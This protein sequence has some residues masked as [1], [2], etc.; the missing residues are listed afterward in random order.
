MW[1]GGVRVVI[2]NEEGK[3]LLVM[4]QH[5]GKE[6]WMVPGGAIEEGESSQDAAIREVMEETGLII[7]LGRLL[8]HV[9]EVGAGRGQRFVNYFLASVIGGK[10]ELGTDPELGEDQVLEGMGFFSKEEIGNL[11]HVYP[12]ALRDEVFDELT[13]EGGSEIY[14]LR[15]KIV[16]TDDKFAEK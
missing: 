8:W 11:V 10:A 5:E 12:D 13:V 2:P 3:I 1:T 15:D 16:C 14:R 6:I 4:Q 7:H 9:E